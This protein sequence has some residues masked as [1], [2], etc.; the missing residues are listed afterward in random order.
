ML[1]IFLATFSLVTLSSCS[2]YQSQ[3]RTCVETRTCLQQYITSLET[4][5][6]Q[7]FCTLSAVSIDDLSPAPLL[8]PPPPP[9][10][11]AAY[12]QVL[13]DNSR[14]L[15]LTST[16]LEQ[17]QAHCTFWF[18]NP[19]AEQNLSASAFALSYDFFNNYHESSSPRIAK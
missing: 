6:A 10:Q 15:L 17:P 13:S 19:T 12:S 1:L 16:P 5:D 3:G 11:V 18:E 2:I 4:F 9:L 14:K 8:L 7:E